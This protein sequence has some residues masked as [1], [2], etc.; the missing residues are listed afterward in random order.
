MCVY[1]EEKRAQVIGRIS[2]RAVHGPSSTTAKDLG[3]RC[4]LMM[5]GCGE[6]GRAVP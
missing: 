5:M 2:R 6:S 3:M 1:G 4:V